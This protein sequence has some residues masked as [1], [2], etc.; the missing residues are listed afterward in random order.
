MQQILLKDTITD[1]LTGLFNRRMFDTKFSL[2]LPALSRNKIFGALI[3]IDL[4]EFKPINDQF[5]H[6]IGDEVLIEFAARLN[7]SSRDEETIARVGGDEFILLVENAGQDQ[8]AAHQSAQ[9]LAMRIQGL[10]REPLN[11]NGLTSKDDL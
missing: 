1:S 4:D 2:L 11:I 8:I 6:V 3:Y 5:G 9:G 7:K 10:M